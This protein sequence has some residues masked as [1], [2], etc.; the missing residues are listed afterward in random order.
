MDALLFAADSES[1]T[2]DQGSSGSSDIKSMTSN[3]FIL[4]LAH[5]YE[6]YELIE[7]ELK[8]LEIQALRH[9]KSLSEE[10]HRF[11]GQMLRVG[12]MHCTVNAK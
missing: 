9:E 11:I 12:M 6:E 7:M 4:D 3:D 2:T 8:Q 10:Q 1:E 5:K